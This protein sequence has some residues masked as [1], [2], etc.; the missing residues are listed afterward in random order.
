MFGIGLPELVVIVVVALI[1]FGPERLPGLARQLGRS[2]TEL[3]RAIEEAKES[4]VNESK[5]TT[6]SHE[7]PKDDQ[8]DAS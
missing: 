6:R 2:V 7:P 5:P 4:F 8:R 1:V 3:K